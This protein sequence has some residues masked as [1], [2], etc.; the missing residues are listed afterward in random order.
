MAGDAPRTAFVL[1]GGGNQ[2]VAQVGMLQALADRGIRPDIVIGT[3]AGALNAAAISYSPD[4]AGVEHLI[5]V[6][7]S[8]TGEK[9]FPGSRL[10][11]VWRMVGRENH[12]FPCDGLDG[13]IDASAPVESFSDLKVPLRVIATDIDTGEEVVFATGP[14]RPA[15][16]ASAAIPGIF[17]VVEHDGRRLVDGGVV[18]SVPISHAI[19]SDVDRVIVMNVSSGGHA[20]LRTPL[21]V[22][23]TSFLHA[24]NQR[25]RRDLR[26][27]PHDVT[28]I[29]MPRPHDDRPMLDFTHAAEI[30]DRAHEL[31]LHALAAH[32]AISPD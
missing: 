1:S 29:Q 4:V 32:A 14:L 21:D 22:V 31:G 19:A 9:V 13:I 30:I 8:L 25:F 28:V 27:V 26:R 12:L 20:R 10:G 5:E 2:A 6:W 7:T 3:S 16:L 24:R 15:L 18:N 23:M 11:R 17:P